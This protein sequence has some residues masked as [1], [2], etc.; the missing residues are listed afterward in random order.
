MD[1]SQAN[2]EQPRG[3]VHI[4]GTLNLNYINVRCVADINLST[5]SGMGRLIVLEDVKI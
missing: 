1:F 2:F 4:E 3:I 5:L